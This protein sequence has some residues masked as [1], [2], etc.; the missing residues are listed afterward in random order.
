M[1]TATGDPAWR[2][3]L[4]LP[5]L[6]RLWVLGCTSVLFYINLSQDSSWGLTEVNMSIP[7]R[8]GGN[9]PLSLCFFNGLTEVLIQKSQ[10][11]L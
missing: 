11:K 4:D 10:F 2:S 9:G 8:A 3:F 6:L 1:S 5:F 7:Q